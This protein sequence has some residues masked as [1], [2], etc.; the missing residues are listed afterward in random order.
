[1]RISPPE[2]ESKSPQFE[3]QLLVDLKVPANE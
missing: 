2:A 1:M 3:T